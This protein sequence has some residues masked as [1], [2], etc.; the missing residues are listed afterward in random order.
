MVPGAV[1]SPKY[2]AKVWDGKKH[3][4][5]FRTKRL[6]FG[7][8]EHVKKFCED[9]DYEC[10]VHFDDSDD[11]CSIKE[12]EDFAK[13]LNLPDG[14]EL[15][16][17][18][19]AMIAHAV[20]QKRMIAISAVNSGKSISQY[21]L[22]RYLNK[23]SILI[24]P[25][26]Q[27]VKQ[28]YDDFSAYSKNDPNWN[29]DE[30]CSQIMEGFSKDNRS[31]RI[32]ITTWQSLLNQPKEWFKEYRVVLVDEVHEAKGQAMNDIMDKNNAPYRIGF[33]GTM[34]DT[35]LHELVL[36]GLFG[37]PK[38]FIRNRE[39]IERKL[40]SDIDIKVIVLKH[41]E[42]AKKFLAKKAN[43]NYP[44]EIKYIIENEDR[45][46]FISNLALSLSG[47]VLIFY[48]YVDKH[49]KVLYDV[50]VNNNTD[51]KK[52]H[53]VSGDVSLD[54]REDIKTAMNTKRNNITVASFGT[55]YRGISIT[56]IDY[57]ILAS[58]VKS[59]NRIG[60]SIGRGLRRGKEKDHVT[61]FDI[62]DDITTPTRKN[63][64]FRHL[65]DRL[66]LYTK[67]GFKFKIFK[68]KLKKT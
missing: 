15:R 9:R 43:K 52:I 29:V 30:K 32:Q 63:H 36:T 22:L 59:Q 41:P 14:I 65:E 60:Q 7:L 37:R 23:K 5:N 62:A 45:N 55:F 56:N 1:H 2:K 44:T 12:I 57:M 8:K 24:V 19:L 34:D 64:T 53:F 4:Y 40:S 28:M 47:N 66:R 42:E 61:L 54:D 10:V 68:T 11:P 67:E 27:L 3:L 38:T 33:T 18:Q 16:D 26:K 17:Y 51:N 31:H 39:M 21:I 50:I 58:P 13:T 25:S 20:R 46:K 35:Q 6:Y 49:G 48:N